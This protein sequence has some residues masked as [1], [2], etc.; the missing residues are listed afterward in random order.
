MIKLHYCE[1]PEGAIEGSGYGLAIAVCAEDEYGKLW[2]DNDEYGNAV[3]YCPF[4]GFKAKVSMNPKEYSD[5]RN[6]WKDEYERME[7]NK[8]KWSIIGAIRKYPPSSSIEK[9]WI[10]TSDGKEKWNAKKMLYQPEKELQGFLKV[11][12]LND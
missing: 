7:R 2:V 12:E 8:R 11:L 9:E 3:N 1:P 4:C 10:R 6:R 5:L